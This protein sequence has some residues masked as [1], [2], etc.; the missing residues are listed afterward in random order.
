M[1]ETDE[2]TTTYRIN[3]ALVVYPDYT[4]DSPRFVAEDAAAKR[5]F[6]LPGSD[7][8]RALGLANEWLTRA[9]FASAVDDRFDFDAPGTEVVD[10]FVDNRFVLPRS[11][12]AS[13]VAEGHRW[14]THGWDD[15]L[16]FYRYTRN[17]PYLDYSEASV[18]RTDQE[19]MEAYLEAEPVPPIYK[20]YDEHPTRSLPDVSEA[21]LS[22]FD[23]VFEETYLDAER[24]EP[25]PF[26]ED[27][28]ARLLFFTFGETGTITFETQGEFLL[29]TSPSGG[30]RHP[31]EAYVAV[32]NV[33]DVPS[34][35]YHYD[36]RSHGLT[37]L[38]DVPDR[39]RL[40]D[41]VFELQDGPGFEPRALVFFTSVLER[42]MWRYREPRSYRVLLHDIGHLVETLR[43]VS[44][45]VGQRAFFGHGFDDERLES[46]LG[47][48]GYEEPALCF[49]AIG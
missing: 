42:S 29:K 10:T 24:R 49:A 30:A 25:E 35:L 26:D 17:Y 19:L 39:D 21:D 43:L 37:H 34:G 4:A 32:L 38:D 27:A 6:E 22:S 16:D 2:S 33:D 14:R 5:R 12:V 44:S 3:P 13:M 1:H 20:T 46:M 31:T 15:A 23:A 45:A 40:D 28:L 36:V 41:V 11:E 18:A 7:T 9:E 48:S 47:V 8:L